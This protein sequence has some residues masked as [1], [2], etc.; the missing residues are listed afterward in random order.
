MMGDVEGATTATTSAFSHSTS[1]AVTAHPIKQE[2]ILHVAVKRVGVEVRNVH[3]ATTKK[4]NEL[5][6]RL[7]MYCSSL[8]TH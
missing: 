2:R 4:R 8:L 6:Q 5:W 3:F 1:S 7:R